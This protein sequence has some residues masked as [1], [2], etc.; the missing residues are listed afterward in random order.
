MTDEISNNPYGVWRLGPPGGKSRPQTELAPVFVP[1]LRAVLA[2]LETDAGRP[3]TKKQVE[4]TRDG[5]TCIAM[6]HLDAQKLERERGYADLNPEF[7]W[8]QW[9]LV[10]P[11]DG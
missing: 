4:A 1:T 3:L 5:A 11:T 8:D 7:V 10:R 9:Q 2:A 6:K